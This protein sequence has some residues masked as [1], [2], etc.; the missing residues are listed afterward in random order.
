MPA[1]PACAPSPCA[2]TAPRPAS[3]TASSPSTSPSRAGWSTT[4]PRS[5]RPCRRRSPSWPAASTSPSPPSASPTSARRSSRGTAA[6]AS[7]CTAPSSGRTAA[8]RPAATSCASEGFE[9]TV[10]ATTGLVLDPYFTRHQGRV[11]AHRGRRA[12]RRPD[13]ALGTIDAWVLWNLTGGPDGGVLATEPSNASRTM[14]FDI[15]TLAWSDELLDRFGVPASRPARGAAVERP[16]R[17]DGR[18]DRACR[19]AS[20]CP[21]SPATSRRPCS[22]RR[23]SSRA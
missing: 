22:A 8:P 2:T 14:L 21:G 11:A 9:P 7:R 17:R 15:R 5:G 19:R 3:R 20:R 23:A 13:L 4:P 6:P 1:P 10:R 18:R 12:S 16:V